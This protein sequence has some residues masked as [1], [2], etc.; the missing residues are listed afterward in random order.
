MKKISLKALTL[1]AVLTTAGLVAADTSDN[2]TT[3]NRIAGYRQWTRVNRE[4]VQVKAM[5]VNA[6]AIPLGETGI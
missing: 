1:V 3:L 4:P 2:E 5:A 6:A